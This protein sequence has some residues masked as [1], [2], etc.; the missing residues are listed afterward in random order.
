M[1]IAWLDEA[2]LSEWAGKKVFLRV[3]FNVPLG[4]EGKILDD[5][6]L[7]LALPTIRRL[8]RASAKVVLVSHLGRPKGK[9][10]EALSLEPVAAYL[11]DLLSQDVIFIH[12]CVG[13]GVARIVNNAEA[14]SI[15]MLENVRFHGGEEKNDPVFAKLLARNMD[16]YVNDAFGAIHRSHASVDGVT[17]YFS[18]TYGGLLLKKEIMAFDQIMKQPKRPL[19]AV[20]GGA[21]IS[22]KI[23]V[24]LTL[25]KKVDAL[26]I[27]G[28][29]AYTF[30]RAQG[31]EV[32]L[33]FVEEDKIV[34]A[35]NLLKKARELSVKI[36]LPQ[37]HV[38]TDDIAKKSNVKIVASEDFPKDSMGVDIGPKTI[39]A[40]AHEI[41][42]AKTIFLNGPMGIYE[43]KEFSHGTRAL[44]EAITNS[45]GFSMVGG[46]DS[47]AALKHAGLIDKVGF[48]STGGGASLEL[49]EGKKL[50]GLVALNYYDL[51]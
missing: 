34:F 1:P 9:P 12:D 2:D 51:T 33:S 47:I 44:M 13:D 49:L 18:K 19:V 17:K 40:Y 22:S 37:D 35:D 8:L 10:K 14:A 43:E 46:G 16:I 38:V 23:G 24:L 28:A 31:H 42:L 11:R 48:V 7:I 4:D 6:R 50:P 32:G 21:K 15:F 41:A 45:Q 26:L 36:Y 20:I 29:M 25:L 5:E 30:L 3:D 27:G 39:E